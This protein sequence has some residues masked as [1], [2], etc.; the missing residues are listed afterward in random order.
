M[1]YLPFIILIPFLSSCSS[2]SNNMDNNFS[3]YPRVRQAYGEKADK[4]KAFLADKSI[5]RSTLNIFIRAFKTE[6]IV[7]IWGKNATDEKYQLV[8]TYDIC[9]NSG[10]LGP[11]RREGDYQVPEGFY[12]IDRFNPKSTYHL[13][14][15]LN[16]P[17][18]SDKILSDKDAP[19][20]DIFIHGKCVTVGCL[21]MTDDKMNEIYLFAELAKRSGQEKIPVHIFPF[22][23]TEANIL[24]YG[25]MTKRY[26]S[27][28]DFW[29]NLKGGYDYF[30]ENR[31]VPSVKV[32]GEGKYVW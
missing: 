19:G 5:D 9:K 17:N 26:D 3:E 2:N 11:K 21:P 22:K 15:G 32:D 12:Y 13:S 1:K 18:A 31:V 20:S 29:E 23:M 6:K 28:I 4:V 7:E 24:K 14:L 25:N 30:E 27:Y 10:D 16:Y 8:T